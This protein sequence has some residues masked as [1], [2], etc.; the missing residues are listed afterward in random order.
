MAYKFYDETYT[1][2]IIDIEWTMGRTGTLTPVAVFEPVE[3]DG[4][5]VER[6]SMHNLSI[7]YELFDGMPHYKQEIEVYKS[8]MIIPQIYS[9]DKTNH[10]VLYYY[11][12]PNF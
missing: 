2:N 3:I 12:Y 6:A 4:T 11:D 7:V 10:G 1:T 8:N 5:T 9:A